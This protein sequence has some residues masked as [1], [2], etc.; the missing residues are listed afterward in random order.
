[1]RESSKVR[2]FGWGVAVA[3]LLGLF[4]AVWGVGQTGDCW[5]N[6]DPDEDTLMSLWPLAVWAAALGVSWACACAYMWARSMCGT[7]SRGRQLVSALTA[8]TMTL[9]LVWVLTLVVS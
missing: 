7:D 5:S 9:P 1:M 8:S 3:L 2:A 6:C 4:V